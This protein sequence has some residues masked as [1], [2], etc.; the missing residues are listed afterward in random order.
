[1]LYKK[2]RILQ[3]EEYGIFFSIVSSK[4]EYNYSVF[5]FTKGDFNPSIK[6]KI[7]TFFLKYLKSPI[8][9]SHS[10]KH[11]LKKDKFFESS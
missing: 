3:I 6:K 1:M 7:K 5:I 11:H 8:I 4:N 2:S 9:A 10:S